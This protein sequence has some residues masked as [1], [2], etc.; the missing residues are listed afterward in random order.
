MIDLTRP[1]VGFYTRADQAP[2]DPTYDPPH[3]AA[4]PI[5]G[6]PITP[7]TCRTVGV[8]WMSEG[9]YARRLSLFFR[10]HRDC[11][12]TLDD[13]ERATLDGQALAIGDA[14]AK[15]MVH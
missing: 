3:D 7:E 1:V 10:L 12:E 15:E 4:C 6:D 14:I 5:C 11:D 13:W 8:M 9:G 2:E